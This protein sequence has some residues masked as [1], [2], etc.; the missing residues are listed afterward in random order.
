MRRFLAAF[1]LLAL[2]GCGLVETHVARDP[3]NRNSLI[4]R[5]VVDLVDCAG[6]PTQTQLTGPDTGVIEYTYKASG[7]PPLQVAL[8]PFSLSFGSDES[9]N[10]VF[11]ILRDGTVADVTFPASQSSLTSGPYAG[12]GVLVAECLAHPGSTQLPPGYDAF[13]YVLKPKQGTTP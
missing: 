5:N 13:K 10:A 4:G 8:T 2:S 1:S 3:M 11:T 12:C 9:C 7:S 6:V